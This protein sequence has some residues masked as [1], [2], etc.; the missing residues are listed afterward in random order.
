MH[1][2]EIVNASKWRRAIKSF[3]KDKIISETHFQAILEVANYG[4][5]S[6][7]LE[8]WSALII[9]EQDVRDEM[10]PYCTGA[11]NQLDSASH[12]VVLTVTKDLTPDSDYFRNIKQ[13]VQGISDSEY[14]EFVSKCSKFH[15]QKVNL[16]DPRTRI[17]WAAK[18]A[19]IALGNMMLAASILEIDSC[20][21]E[22][23]IP[24]KVESIL[25]N[26]G[27][28]DSKN[29]KIVAMVAFG[30]RESEPKKPKT[31]RPYDEVFKF[32]K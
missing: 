26:R 32:I 16:N 2:E 11:Q 13:K 21:I 5:T 18:Q 24:D 28:F 22:G 4:P 27:I 20:P 29:N 9:Q 17:D 1:P 3:Q 31:R 8:P 10:R 6:L 30:Y 12:F 14:L 25:H 15:E 7:G 23:F 19:Y